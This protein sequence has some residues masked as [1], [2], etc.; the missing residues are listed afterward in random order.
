LAYH[1]TGD[2]DLTLS[3]VVQPALGC[4]PFCKSSIFVSVKDVYDGHSYNYWLALQQRGT[5]MDF[6]RLYEVSSVVD[7]HSDMRLDIDSMT[8]EVCK[9]HSTSLT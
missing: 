8:Y 2:R 4:R 3:P 7:E 6:S 5:M 1:F 9:A